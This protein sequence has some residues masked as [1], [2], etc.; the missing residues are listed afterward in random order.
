MFHYEEPPFPRDLDSWMSSCFSVTKPY[1]DPSNSHFLHHKLLAELF[2]PHGSIG[3]KCLLSKL[4][5]SF[6][7]FLR[8]LNFTQP[9]LGL[10]YVCAKSLQLCLTV[11]DHMGCSPPGSSVRRILQPRILKWVAICSSRG[12]SQPRLQPASL[13]FPALAGRFFTTSTTWEPQL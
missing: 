12:S 6:S 10:V 1:T 9:Q 13:R 3:T 2:C 8:S 4:C 11:Y 5:F 7:P